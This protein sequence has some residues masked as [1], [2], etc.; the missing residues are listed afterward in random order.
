MRYHHAL[1]DVLQ[2][3]VALVIDVAG[4]AAEDEVGIAARR[5][6][7]VKRQAPRVLPEWGCWA[8]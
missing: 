2:V 6:A 8:K 1:G 5:L 7:G 4:V 3:V